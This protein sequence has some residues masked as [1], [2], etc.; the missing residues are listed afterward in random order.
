LLALHQEPAWALSQAQF[1]MLEVARQASFGS[2]HLCKGNTNYPNNLTGEP[3][4][5][6]NLRARA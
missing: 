5:E 4:T 2:N 3:V 1:A 6:T